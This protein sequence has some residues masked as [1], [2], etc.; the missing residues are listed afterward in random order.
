VTRGLLVLFLLGAG[1]GAGACDR[2]REHVVIMRGMLFE[3]AEL[4]VAAGDRVVWRNEDIV[5]H[6]ATAA[7]RFD[8]GVVPPGE[9]ARVTVRAR[10]AVRYA[11]TL[12]PM[13]LGSLEVR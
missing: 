5:A 10:G 9:S 13:M 4:V 11:C 3:P 12:H 1:L 2:G 7:G 6:T 8:T